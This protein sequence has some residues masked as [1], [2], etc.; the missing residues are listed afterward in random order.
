MVWREALLNSEFMARV[1]PYPW[2]FFASR[3]NSGASLSL[4]DCETVE[5]LNPESLT[6]FTRAEDETLPT[7]AGHRHSTAPLAHHV[8]PNPNS[9]AGRRPGVLSTPAFPHEKS[10]LWHG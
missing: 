3:G 7:F 1:L 2:S 8:L 4:E 5:S 6:F 10:D 9:A